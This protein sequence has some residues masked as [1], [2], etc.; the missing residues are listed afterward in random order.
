MRITPPDRYQNLPCSYVGTGCAYEDIYHIPFSGP[1]PEGL[2]KDGYLSLKKMDTYIRQYLS[3]K[4]KIYFSKKQRIPLREFLQHNKSPA[5]ICV[6]GHFVYA[7]N[8][9][10]TSFFDNEDDPI[11]CIW[12]LNEKE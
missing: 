5:G 12:Y 2:R 4:K 7:N 3:V 10:Y 8:G 6:Y 9:D 1:L 11:V